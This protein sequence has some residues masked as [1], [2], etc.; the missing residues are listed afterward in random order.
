MRPASRRSKTCL[1]FA[2]TSISRAFPGRVFASATSSFHAPDFRVALV[3]M[4]ENWPVNRTGWILPHSLS[5]A[6]AFKFTSTCAAEFV[7]LSGSHRPVMNKSSAVPQ[8]VLA[9]A[10]CTKTSALKARICRVSARARILISGG[11]GNLIFS[12]VFRN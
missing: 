9:P 1:I 11:S 2:E 12:N 8:G 6:L 4:K 7:P 10:E 3:G 5:K